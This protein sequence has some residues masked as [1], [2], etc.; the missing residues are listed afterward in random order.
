MYFIFIRLFL[1]CLLSPTCGSQ[2]AL[3]SPVLVSCGLSVNSRIQHLANL[4]TRKVW[5][6]LHCNRP[7]LVYT[8]VY[9]LL[10]VFFVLCTLTR[11]AIVLNHWIKIRIARFLC[12]GWSLALNI[13]CERPHT[14]NTLTITHVILCT[15]KTLVCDIHTHI[16]HC[17]QTVNTICNKDLSLLI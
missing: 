9:S 15:H 3:T 1:C 11:F 7:L 14:Q 10:F 4:Y 13:K 16:E 17:Y 5:D 2:L 12:N 6:H 8:Q